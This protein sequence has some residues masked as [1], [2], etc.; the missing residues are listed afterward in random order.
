MG[1]QF[2]SRLTT[3]KILKQEIFNHESQ[4][5]MVQQHMINWVKY[6]LLL[7][8]ILKMLHIKKVRVL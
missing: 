2:P 3:D 6:S 5:G 1:V 8:K 7:V 4:N